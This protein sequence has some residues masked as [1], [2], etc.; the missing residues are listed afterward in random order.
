MSWPDI[1]APRSLEPASYSLHRVPWPEGEEH[2]GPIDIEDAKAYARITN[3]AENAI[4]ASML[5]GAIEYAETATRRT[6]AYALWDLVMDSFPSGVIELRRPPVVEVVE[7][8]HRNA[9]D[10]W[11]VIDPAAYVVEIDGDH[12]TVAP[13]IGASWPG[14][15]SAP[16]SVRVRYSAGY[17]PHDADIYLDPVPSLIGANLN[18]TICELFTFRFDTRGMGSSNRLIEVAVPSSIDSALWSERADW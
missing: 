11:V 15:S 5:A 12:A 2:S 9:S 13:L 7:I 17:R 18:S 10:A 8:Q 16:R 3:A 14:V 6:I 4:V 1:I